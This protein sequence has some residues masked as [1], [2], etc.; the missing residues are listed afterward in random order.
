[1]NAPLVKLSPFNRRCSEISHKEMRTVLKRLATS[2]LTN[3]KKLDAFEVSMMQLLI[4][5]YK[6]D[7]KAASSFCSFFGD[8]QYLMM[9]PKLRSEM[10][11]MMFA[12]G[13]PDEAK[14]RFAFG[15]LVSVALIRHNSL[16]HR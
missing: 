1:M 9:C 8:V 12:D 13:Q 2:G 4:E 5:V 14:I 3:P 6:E 7:R 16:M 15:L 10:S 11:S